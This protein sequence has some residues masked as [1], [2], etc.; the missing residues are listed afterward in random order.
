MLLD[1]IL[2]LNEELEICSEEEPEKFA[3][4]I[5]ALANIYTAVRL[6]SEQKMQ[7]NSE[8]LEELLAEAFTENWRMDEEDYFNSNWRFKDKV[9]EA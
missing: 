7:I 4:V 6:V 9:G 8:E 5:N 2:Q 3:K 1:D